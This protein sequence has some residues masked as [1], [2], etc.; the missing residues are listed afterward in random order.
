MSQDCAG[1]QEFREEGKPAPAFGAFPSTKLKPGQSALKSDEGLDTCQG[2]S[3]FKL[4]LHSRYGTKVNKSSVT[5]HTA[6]MKLTATT[7]NSSFPAFLSAPSTALLSSRRART[8]FVLFT[9]VPTVL[10]TVPDTAGT[11]HVSGE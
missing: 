9:A 6:R 2:H 3:K 8:L 5:T 7:T 4:L 10:R 11:Q 1:R